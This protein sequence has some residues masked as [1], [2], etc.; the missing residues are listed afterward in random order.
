MFSKVNI[1]FDFVFFL[2]VLDV[3]DL[4][5]K[6]MAEDQR[7]FHSAKALLFLLKLAVDN[8]KISFQCFHVV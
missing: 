4:S 6:M 5:F 7:F 8:I 1:R 3:I 2:A